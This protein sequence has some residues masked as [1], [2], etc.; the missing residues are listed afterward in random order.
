MVWQIKKKESDFMAN[1]IFISGNVAK[2][3]ELRMTAGKGTPVATTSIAVNDGY[4]ENKKTYF[5]NIVVWGKQAEF[6]ANNVLKGQKVWVNGKL[7]I[8]DYEAKDGTK[9]Y[10]TE[11]VADMF[12]GVEWAKTSNASSNNN[13][14]DGLNDPVDDDLNELP[15]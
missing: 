6:F 8:R 10:I 5:V 14:D 13:Y 3:I 9:K 12:D 1:R 2:D 4:G 11:V 7:V 15:F